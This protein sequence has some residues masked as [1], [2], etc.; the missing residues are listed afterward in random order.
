LGSELAS[1]GIDLFPE[2]L[3][4]GLPWSPQCID[5]AAGKV[6]EVESLEDIACI[7]GEDLVNQQGRDPLLGPQ[8]RGYEGETFC[9][10]R[11]THGH[12]Y[13]PYVRVPPLRISTLRSGSAPQSPHI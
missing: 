10:A 4:A 2:V 8:Y 6:S 5:D 12:G 13:A 3:R 11:H 7:L 9:S 1:A